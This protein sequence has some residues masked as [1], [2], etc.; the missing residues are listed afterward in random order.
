MCL[1]IAFFWIDLATVHWVALVFFS[2][3]EV[4]QAF[5]CT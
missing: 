3:R 5:A 4:I 1:G 2:V